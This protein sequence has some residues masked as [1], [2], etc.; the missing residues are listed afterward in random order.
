MIVAAPTPEE[1]RQGA[2]SPDVG[3][4]AGGGNRGLD[5][6]GLAAGSHDPCSPEPCSPEASSSG[7]DD[8]LF[9]VGERIADLAAGI[10]AAEGKMMTLLADF[11]RRGGWKDGFS[12]RDA[13]LGDLI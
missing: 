9:L 5:G 8:E 13:I 2:S 11:D 12:F 1:G 10:N 3:R 6:S 4:G 7:E